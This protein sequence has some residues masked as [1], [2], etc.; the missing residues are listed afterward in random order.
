MFILALTYVKPNEEAD[1]HM[2]PHMAWVKEG[3]ARGWFLASGR[4][5][6]RTGGVVLAVGSRADIEAYV[7]ADPFTI[8]GVAQYEITE[9]A[10]TTA[11]DGMEALKG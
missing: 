5:V 2:E 8:H 10:I 9:V 3:Y 1:K 11:V 4:K 7:A 6:P